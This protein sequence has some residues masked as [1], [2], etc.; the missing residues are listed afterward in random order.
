MANCL[1]YMFLCT[2][3]H[4]P[5]VCSTCSFDMFNMFVIHAHHVKS[6][7]TYMF[8]PMFHVPSACSFLVAPASLK[9]M[10]TS[11]FGIPQI[12]I[13]SNRLWL[14]ALNRWGKALIH[15]SIVHNYH[16][17][18]LFPFRT[19]TW[20]TVS[21]NYLRQPNRY[22]TSILPTRGNE[23]TDTPFEHTSS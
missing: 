6:T 10:R 12:D 5:L 13:L 16:H 15:T 18:Y 4:V 19:R 14:L 21:V 23:R 8:F 2:V 20:R 11:S 1:P 9:M 3:R 7:C 17:L 22:P